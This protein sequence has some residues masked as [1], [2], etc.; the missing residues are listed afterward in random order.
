MI[1]GLCPLYR[2]GKGVK[3]IDNYYKDTNFN[4][5]NRARRYNSMILWLSHIGITVG[6]LNRSLSFYLGELVFPILSD[7]EKRG[8]YVE[9]I[10]GIPGFHIGCNYGR[11]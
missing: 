2:N 1:V 5:F 7:A 4:S 11:D 6:D 8:K 10:I 3:D 9:K